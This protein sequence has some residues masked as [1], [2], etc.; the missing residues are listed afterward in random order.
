MT[1]FTFSVFAGLQIAFALP[2]VGPE[3]TVAVEPDA[4][5]EGMSPAPTAIGSSRNGGSPFEL[6]KRGSGNTCGYINAESSLLSQHRPP[7][8]EM[9]KSGQ[10]SQLLAATLMTSARQM[11]ITA[12]TAV[13]RRMAFLPV[14]SPPPAF[15]TWEMM[16][17]FAISTP[18]ARAATPSILTVSSIGLSSQ[19]PRCTTS[20][21]SPLP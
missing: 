4:A 17:P 14:L 7:I 8:V 19:Q 21:A 10:V 6:F 2:W 3:P 13:A 1:L 16:V 9:L 20:V 11:H 15:H 5:V 18:C 12:Y